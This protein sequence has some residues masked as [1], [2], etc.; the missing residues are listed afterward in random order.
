MK[1]VL[2]Y[3]SVRP[4]RLV[5]RV[6]CFVKD[7]VEANG[8]EVTLLDPGEMPFEILKCPLHFY[9]DILEAPD[10]LVEANE[11]IR[12]AECFLVVSAEYNATIPPALSNMLDHFNMTSYR[13]KPL[14]LVTYS[15]GHFGGIRAAST[16]RQLGIELGMVP[17]PANA[18]IPMAETTFDET[19]IC[20]DERVSSRILRLVEELRWYATALS[21]YKAIE[22]PPNAPQYSLE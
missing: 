21:S 11:K 20:L 13:H 7:L 9:P 3:G 12:D 6:G 16:I 18:H 1:L 15:M 4:G 8:F 10:W 14:G 19:G 17:I 5:D 22:A 2:F